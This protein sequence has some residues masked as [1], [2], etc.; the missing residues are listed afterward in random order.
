MISVVHI[1]KNSRLLLECVWIPR[2]SCKLMWYPSELSRMVCPEAGR[3][4]WS[5]IFVCLVMNPSMYSIQHNCSI[6]S[7]FLSPWFGSM[8]TIRCCSIYSIPCGNKICGNLLLSHLSVC[9]ELLI[10]ISLL[11]PLFCDRCFKQ[12]ISLRTQFF[13]SWGIME[14]SIQEEVCF[15]SLSIKRYPNKCHTCIY[16][17]RETFH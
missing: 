5:D 11:N 17:F 9:L 15:P 14:E 16:L 4:V 8:K 3:R 10:S 7:W 2:C 1:L 13:F 12:Q 6:L